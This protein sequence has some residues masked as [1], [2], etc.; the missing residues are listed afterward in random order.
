M[1]ASELYQQVTNTIIADLEAGVAPWVKPWTSN[2]GGGLPYNASTQR[3]YN[4]INIPILWHAFSRNPWPTMGFMTYRQAQAVGAQVKEGEKG[5][6]VVFTKQFRVGDKESEEEK[7]IGILRNFTVFN[8]GQIE[9]LP[10]EAAAVPRT[11]EQQGDDAIR[12]IHATGA[13]I[14]HGGDRACYVPSKDFIIL[15]ETSA[16]ES[17]QHY[18]A[19]ALHECVHWSGA[20]SRLGRD[21]NNRFGSYA[22]AAEELVAEL[23]AAFLCAH[24]GVQGQLRSAEYM[25]NWLE[26]LREDNRAIF[27]AASKASQAA[28]YL[29]GF[30][31]LITEPAAVGSSAPGQ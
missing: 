17:D 5:T 3:R 31:E 30:S 23:G 2:G 26:L 12:F 9:G 16:F 1:R 20:A 15:P 10:Q 18:L 21:L 25:A 28:D 29:R 24:L 7:T 4:G 27:T 13:E 8:V 6:H 11:T 14:K 22:N 19:T